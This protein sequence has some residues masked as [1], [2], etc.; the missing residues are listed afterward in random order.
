MNTPSASIQAWARQLLA[1]EAAH[2]ST[3]GLPV[4][5]AVQVSEKL[6]ISLTRFVGAD[7]FTA[8]LRRAVALARAEV[9]ALRNVRVTAEGR[10]EGMKEFAAD[11][12]NG[13]DA[14]TAITEH[15][16]NLLVNFVGV[17]LTLRLMRDAWPDTSWEEKL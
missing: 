6:R 5:E 10:L 3:S 17:S 11:A 1:V 8:L 12:G 14:A 2:P 15:L 9:P 13:V 16:L 4:Q 7:G